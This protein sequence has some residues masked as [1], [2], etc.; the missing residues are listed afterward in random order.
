LPKKKKKVWEPVW[1]KPP[2]GPWGWSSHLKRQKKKKKKLRAFGGGRTAPRPLGVAEPPP[3]AWSV[4]RGGS[5][6][7]KTATL[8]PPLF[9][10]KKIK[11]FLF[12]DL[13]FN[14]LIKSKQ[15]V[16]SQL[17]TVREKVTATNFIVV[18]ND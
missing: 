10:F 9:F 15:C 18:L 6:T 3:R 13:K 12:V 17:T 8:V 11:L 1:P 5:V 7:L 16:L 2:L 14:I 4:L